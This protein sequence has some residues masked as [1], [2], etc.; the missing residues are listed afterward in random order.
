MK[1]V[2]R[3]EGCST[4]HVVKYGPLKKL[5]Y[6]TCKK[7]TGIAIIDP[8]KGTSSSSTSSTSSRRQPDLCPG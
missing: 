7:V 1:E 5:A 8:I 6:V 3:I 2:G 4:P